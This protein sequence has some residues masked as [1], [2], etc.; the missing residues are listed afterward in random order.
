MGFTVVA[1]GVETP[2]ELELL[3]D[4]V[5]DMI[6]GFYFSPPV[7]CGKLLELLAPGTED[8]SA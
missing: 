5:V 8:G 3:S 7:S 6:Q 2:A 1:E 4:W